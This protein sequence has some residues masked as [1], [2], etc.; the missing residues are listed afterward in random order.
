MLD[1]ASL[2]VEGREMLKTPAHRT[3][4]AVQDLLL[5][6]LLAAVAWLVS[7]NQSTHSKLHAVVQQ[8]ATHAAAV[9]YSDAIRASVQSSRSQPPPP[10]QPAPTPP[11][12]EPHASARADIGQG[13]LERLPFFFPADPDKNEVRSV[14]LLGAFH[15]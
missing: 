12:E 4:G 9:P 7:Q 2:R 1:Y 10:S 6:V 14:G 11:A 8:S 3:R 13:P 5:L 15:I